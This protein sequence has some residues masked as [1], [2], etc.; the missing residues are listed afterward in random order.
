ML[1]V[2]GDKLMDGDQ[3]SAWERLLSDLRHQENSSDDPLLFH[4][5]SSL[6][7]SLILADGFDPETAWVPLPMRD[8]ALGGVNPCVFW[9]PKLE[10][11]TNR[12]VRHGG[13]SQGLPVIL[14]A[15][16]N[17]MAASGKPVPDYCMWEID[18]QEDPARL[19]KDWMESLKMLGA[20][21]VLD[22]RRVAGLR[23]HAVA[24]LDHRP[25]S[26]MH[27]AVIRKM[28]ETTIPAAA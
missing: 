20:I 11:A 13:L 3:S 22:C 24:P 5:T 12:A 10:I 26:A 18:Y 21:A 14:S 28:M 8:G 25:S 19:P 23:L 27:D 2:S 16:A 17:D 15:R 1:F 7:A 6:R 4:G 9:T